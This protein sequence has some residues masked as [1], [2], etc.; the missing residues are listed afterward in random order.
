ML[1]DIHVHTTRYSECG[2]SDPD[3]MIKAAISY[4][5]DG[6]VITEHNIPWPVTELD[7]LRI[8]YPEFLILR[9]A[10]FTADVGDHYVTFG[11]DDFEPLGEPRPAGE[12]ITTIQGRGGV[13]ILAHPYRYGPKVPL[14]T[15]QNTPVDAIEVYSNNVIRH[16]HPKAVALAEKFGLP[17]TAASDAHIVHHVGLYALDVPDTVRTE[18]DLAEVVRAGEFTR[19]A[20]VARLRVQNDDLER[21]LPAI[22]AAIAQGLTND[23]IRTELGPFGYHLIDSLRRSLAVGWPYEELISAHA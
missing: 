10:E 17:M 6:L 19:W 13:A 23:E 22:R 4:G 3:D 1:I 16:A 14:Q 15:L 7:E 9:G 8:R 21:N 20:D 2:K 11:V 12:I 5:L 18:H